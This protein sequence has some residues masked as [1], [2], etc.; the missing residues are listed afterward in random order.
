MKKKALLIP[1]L[2]LAMSLVVIGCPAPAPAPAPASTPQPVLVPKSRNLINAT[3]T[4]DPGDYY[5][6][7]F[8]ARINGMRDVV[9]LGSF[10]ASGGSGNDII[11]LLLDDIA[12]TNWVNRHKVVVLYYSGQ[13]TTDRINVPITASGKYHLVFSNRFSTISTKRV[14]TTIDL[15]W[16]EIQYR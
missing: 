2:L 1:L 14:L 8:S 7:S 10:T 12:Y 13:V 5:H 9:M 16:L 11:V 4:V 3:I 15:E 6:V